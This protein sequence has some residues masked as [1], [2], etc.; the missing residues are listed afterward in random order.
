MAGYGPG[1]GDPCAKL[2]IF[3]FLHQ[4]FEDPE[5]LTRGVKV[6]T[7]GSIL[8]FQQKRQL[9][10]C[11]KYLSKSLYLGIFITNGVY[12]KNSFRDKQKNILV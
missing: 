2:M 8:G 10:R 1:L 6:W 11:W 12:F 9:L 5:G 7:I 3:L 4:L